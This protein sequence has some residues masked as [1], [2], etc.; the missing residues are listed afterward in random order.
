ML[1]EKL[2]KVS[3]ALFCMG[4]VC[5]DVSKQHISGRDA[6][7]KI[8]GY[9][10]DAGMWSRFKVDQLID[11]CMEQHVCNA[12]E[13]PDREWL[14]KALNEQPIQTLEIN[15]PDCCDGCSNN[16][17]N[18]GS[19]ICNCTLPYMQNP[20]TYTVP[21]EDTCMANNIDGR[22]YFAADTKSLTEHKASHERIAEAVARTQKYIKEV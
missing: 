20:T 21:Y 15:Y 11:D 10:N 3:K 14:K 18:G 5:V 7:N 9:L 4:E 8:R 6:L 17:K 2:Y 22:V 13:E 16:P 1:K 19:G 12:F